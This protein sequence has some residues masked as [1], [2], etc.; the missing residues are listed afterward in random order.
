[1]LQLVCACNS[2]FAAH[3]INVVQHLLA[4]QSEKA[5]MAIAMC[6]YENGLAFNLARSPSFKEMVDAIAEAGSDKFSKAAWKPPSS[7]ALRTTLLDKVRL[8]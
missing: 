3:T 5:D 4:L 7:E 2:A 6:F 1:M 8:A